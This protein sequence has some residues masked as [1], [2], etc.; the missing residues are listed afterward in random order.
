MGEGLQSLNFLFAV[1]VK[2]TADLRRK[3][4]FPSIIEK[5]C[6]QAGELLPR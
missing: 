6:R 4:L 5:L 3:V 1:A 2:F